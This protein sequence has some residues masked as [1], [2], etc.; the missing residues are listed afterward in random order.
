VD[1]RFLLGVERNGFFRFFINVEAVTQA[2]SGAPS[3]IKARRGK[4]KR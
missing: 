1:V 4:L 3:Q 2:Q